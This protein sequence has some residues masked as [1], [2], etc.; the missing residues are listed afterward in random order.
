MAKVLLNKLNKVYPNGFHAVYDAELTIEDKEFMVLVGPSGCGKTTTLRMIAGLE[1]IST[2]EMFIGEKMVNDV[3]PKDRDIAMVFQNYALYPHMSVRDNM[4]FGL[5]LRKTPKKE[6]HERVQNAA[7][8]LGIESLLDR[9][10]KQLSGGQRQRVAL[11][12]AIVRKPQVFLMDEPLSNLDAKLRVQMRAELIKLHRELDS[13]FIYVTHDQ[14]EA[15]TM[16]TKICVMKDGYIQ[17]VADPKTIYNKPANLFVAGFIG[18][19]Q[20]NL[21]KAEVVSGDKIG[22]KFHGKTFY[23]TKPEIVKNL[24]DYVGKTVIMGIRPEDM[25]INN[26][27]KGIDIKIEVTELLGSEILLYFNVDGGEVIAKE[28]PDAKVAIGDTINIYFDEEKLH[29]FDA[30]TELSLLHK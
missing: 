20:M 8:I 13:T 3:A 26:E 28:K 7:S 30:E 22:L 24:A 1:E 14:T 2:G 23:P 17:Q 12:R 16:G 25:H 15:M 18:S 4:S 10:P 27:N 19:P 11:G 5:K 6:I 9:K 21:M 29:V